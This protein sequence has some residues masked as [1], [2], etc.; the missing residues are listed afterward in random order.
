M[1][2]DLVA[3][4]ALAVS[5]GAQALPSLPLAP[6]FQSQALY[7]ET[8]GPWVLHG[9]ALDPTGRAL[10]AGR[11]DELWRIEP[12]QAPFVVLRLPAGSQFGVVARPP[13]SFDVL[14]TDATR[15]LLYRHDALNRRTTAGQV[16][17]HTFDLEVAPSGALL[18]SANPLWPQQGAQ[19]G[20]WLVDESNGRHREIL[21]LSGPSGP[22]A[23][24]AAGNLCYATQTYTFPTPPGSVRVLRFAAAAVQGAIRGGPALHESDG[25]LLLR[26]DGAYDLAFDDRDRLH[27]TDP[28]NGGIVRT[29]PGGGALEERLAGLPNLPQRC[30]TLALHWQEL[31]AG[32]FD[33][34]QPEDGGT[35]LAHAT[36]HGTSSAVFAIRAAR[37]RLTTPANPVPPGPV[38]IDAAGLPAGGPVVLLVSSQPP[39]AERPVLT[40]GGVPLWCALA[41]VPAPVAIPGTSSPLGAA[42]FDFMHPGGFTVTLR[43]QAV[44]AAGSRFGSTNPLT[45]DLQ[46]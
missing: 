31:G 45:L 13:R 5:A 30:G 9:C 40:L 15:H 23:F 20:V 36:D 42:R 22:L 44:G 34:F 14:C 1:N 25:T 21:Q 35:L 10:F 39:V 4:C 43:Q 6:G 29:I 8:A 38:R 12:N 16:P 24:D 11:Y 17:R 27:V 46:R 19:A 37:P 26:L 32:T 33:P 41:L 7:H 3:A 2:R 18:A 28:H